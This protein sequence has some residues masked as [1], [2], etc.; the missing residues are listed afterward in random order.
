[1]FH[2]VVLMYGLEMLF[3]MALDTVY[4]ELGGAGYRADG[5][6]TIFYRV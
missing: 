1:M 5:L 3:E 6:F 2:V 4:R